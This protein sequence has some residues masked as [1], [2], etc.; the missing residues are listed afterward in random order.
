[1]KCM[2]L[3][4]E[5]GDVVSEIGRNDPDAKRIPVQQRKSIEKTKKTNVR[6][7]STRVLADSIGRFQTVRP[8]NVR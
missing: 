8:R 6:S 7:A 3:A 2:H 4:Q 5:R 1:M